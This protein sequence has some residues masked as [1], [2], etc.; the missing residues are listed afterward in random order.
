MPTFTAA[1]IAEK[2]GARVI[3]DPQLPLSGFAPADSAKNGDLTFAEN[4]AYFERASQS[5][6]SAILVAE[7]FPQGHQT[8]IRVA[9][10]RVAFA[11]ILPMFFPEPI[12]S[13][14]IHPTALVAPSALVDSTAHVGPYCVVGERVRLGAGVVLQGR[15]DIGDDS[16]L[17]DGCRLFPRVTLY[18]RTQCG[19][20]VRLH[21]G[22]VIGSD[23]F[24]YVFDQGA[25]RKVPQVGQVILQDDV[26]VGANTT[27]DRAALGATIIGKGTKVDNLVQIGHNV[28]IGEHG[29][30]V[31]QVGIAGSTKIGAHAT[32]AGQ[33]G[34]AGHL[35]IGDGV[36]IAAK[37][38]VM[39][40]I[41]DG[42]KWLGAPA[43]PDRIAKRKMLAM[44]RLPELLRRVSELER[45]AGIKLDRGD[46]EES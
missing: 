37:A 40:H 10:A 23:G 45:H 36:T 39:H 32:I 18:P 33:V 7:D 22:V 11:Q 26:E 24:G 1:Q 27:I 16:V 15:D 43:Q 4:E 20:R 13:P 2:L 21:A 30:I 12:F 31:S 14:G 41:P 25:H 29:I 35:R 44:E 6:A 17:G 38:G 34:I 46:S 8:L 3:G 19:A 28:T 9:Q 5:A 42:Q